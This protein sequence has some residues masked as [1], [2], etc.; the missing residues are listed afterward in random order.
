METV[1]AGHIFGESFDFPVVCKARFQFQAVVGS[2]PRPVRARE[3]VDVAHSLPPGL[4]NVSAGGIGARIF[5]YDGI[6]WIPV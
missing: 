1:V 6:S 4:Y 2:N 3:V 5:N